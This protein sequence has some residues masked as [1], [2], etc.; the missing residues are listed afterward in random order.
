MTLSGGERQRL[1]IA[2]ALVRRPQLLLLDEPT[3]QLDRAN[4]AAI[5]RTVDEI[6][7][8]CAVLVAAHRRS[9][10]QGAQQIVLL[11][12]NATPL[13]TA[14]TNGLQP[15]EHSPPDRHHEERR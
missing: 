9:T 10:I 3:A 7:A 11:D 4:A 8:E 14:G 5:T 1:A 6:S 12:G 13:T 2:R 15:A